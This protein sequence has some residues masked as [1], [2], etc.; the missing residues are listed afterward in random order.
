MKRNKEN[1]KRDSRFELLRIF[2]MVMIVLAHYSWHGG[3]YTQGNDLNKM[4]MSF[5]AIGGKLGVDLFVIISAWFLSG[6]ITNEKKSFENL[7][8]ISLKVTIYSL[9]ACIICM[10][11]KREWSVIQL[12]K[13][14]LGLFY[15]YWFVIIYLF[16]LLLSPYINRMIDHLEQK[17][18]KKLICIL[19]IGL[20]LVP[21]IFIGANEIS[22]EL[23]GF[24]TIYIM[25][26]YRKKYNVALVKK[27]YLIA[28]ASLAIIMIFE[29]LCDKF[30]VAQKGVLIY[31]SYSILIVVLSFSI[32]E[33][34][35]RK[36][37]F[38]SSSI[39]WIASS[40][41][42]VYLFHENQYIR[43]FLWRG[44][45]C[46]DYYDSEWMIIHAIVCLFAIMAIGILI[47]KLYEAVNF[48]IFDHIRRRKSE[49]VF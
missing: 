29:M 41:F 27:P 30:F 16:M 9:G 25:V 49:E 4:I 48:K 33:V 5:F 39:N 38:I 3:G 7:A 26:S 24:L 35:L 20:C 19:L 2:S 31:H 18:H 17:E 47:D 40:M 13:S 36:R 34:V 32:F 10:S 22:S 8:R 23:A 11:L 6:R 14:G 44:L 43:G 46:S 1:E 15:D 37:T 21:T 42:G 12:I 45:Q 28:A